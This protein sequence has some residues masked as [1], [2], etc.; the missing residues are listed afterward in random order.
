M[1]AVIGFAGFSGSGKT[2]LA[3]QVVGL[4]R[5]RGARVA[6]IKHDG[7]GHYKEAEGSDSALYISAGAAQVVVVSPD[8][9]VTYEA[10]SGVT[11][12]EQL[13]RMGDFDVM[14]V[15]GFKG[16]RHAKIAVF[17]NGEQAEVLN[18]LANVVAV[19]A[20]PEVAAEAL[21][22][23]VEAGAG[24]MADEAVGDD[25]VV[26]VFAPDDVEGVADFVVGF[27][28]LVLE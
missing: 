2:T 16:E 9:V 10:R 24:A 19:V 3:T 18:R 26:P 23:A 28:G 14:L 12:D 22:R 5:G 13:Q 8:A 1:A 4:L 27:A 25:A 21:G 15:E 17:R 7:H 20:P 11:L 6:V